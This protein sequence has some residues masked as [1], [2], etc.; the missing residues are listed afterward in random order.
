MPMMWYRMYLVDRLGKF[1]W[2]HDLHAENDGDA[3]AMTHAAQ[4]ACSDVPVGVELWQG[5]RRIPGASGR[6]AMVLR[7]SWKAV[8]A[9]KQEALL[10]TEE[11]LHNSGTAIARSRRLMERI[12]ATRQAM[13]NSQDAAAS[14]AS[15]ET[16]LPDV[17]A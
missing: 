10:R 5:A 12:E 15:A 17:R 13:Q 6:S 2:P 3:L 7:A 9:R 11:A 4:Y 16:R 14:R 8:L 1:R